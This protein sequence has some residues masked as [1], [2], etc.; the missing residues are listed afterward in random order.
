MP[1]DDGDDLDIEVIPEGLEYKFLPDGDAQLRAFV[2]EYMAS[3]QYDT[4]TLLASMATA[5]DW[6]KTGKLPEK[7]NIRAL[8][9]K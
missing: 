4:P 1:P 3:P 2:F 8:H 7:G 5:F 9:Q 6:L